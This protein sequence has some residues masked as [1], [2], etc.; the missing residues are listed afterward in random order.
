MQLGAP[1]L[2]FTYLGLKGLEALHHTLQTR[3]MHGNANKN[4]DDFF[5]IQGICFIF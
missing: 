4:M 3:E 5:P 1:Y 2:N